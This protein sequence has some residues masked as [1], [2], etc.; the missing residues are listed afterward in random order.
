MK[1][2]G[3][4]YLDEWIQFNG[5]TGL[6]WPNN[7]GAH[8]Y[9]NTATS[10]AG[11]M[12]QGARGGYCGLHCGPNTNY[13]T[14]MST[15]THHGLYCESTGWEVYYNRSNTYIGLRTSYIPYPITMD[16]D[17]YTTGWS[18]AASGFY[19]EG[20]GVHYT[21][22]GSVGEINMTSNNEFLWG[23][24]SATLYFNYRT[25]S[26][27]TTI[28]NYIWN[29]GSSTSYASH[30]LGKVKA[31]STASS[32]L[33][34]QRY[35]RGGFNLMDAADTGSYWPWMR[36]TNTGSGK[37]YSMGVLSNSLYFIGSTISRTDNGYD[38]GFRMDFSNGYL[39]GNFSGYLSGTASN[40]TCTEASGDIPR[41]IVGVVNNSLYYTSKVTI[42]WDNGNV[43][44]P[45]FTGRLIGSADKV[46]GYNIWTGTKSQY[47]SAT[48]NNNTIY[49][50]HS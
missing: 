11:L 34:G 23:S 33:D 9:A 48:K 32:W 31:Q 38:Y 20:T 50:I 26:R 29:A 35:E 19:V 42:R 13:M 5:G 1:S 30:V 36:Q 22:Q 45:T 15:D 10:F 3:R 8:L 16:G 21:S 4:V 47:N 12:T 49:I 24:S 25:V 17:S 14:V 18:R 43:T 28:T 39:Y 44:A 37:W 46:N 6:Y 41:P 40:V 7:N 27:G 2:T